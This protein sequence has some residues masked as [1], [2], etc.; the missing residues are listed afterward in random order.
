[1]QQ[2]YIH[3]SCSKGKITVPE[4]RYGSRN[5]RKVLHVDT[6]AILSPTSIKL[7]LQTLCRID[8]SSFLQP[9]LPSSTSIW[10]AS[11]MLFSCSTPACVHG[12]YVCVYVCASPNKVQTLLKMWYPGV[13]GMHY[14]ADWLT[15]LWC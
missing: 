9:P 5:A 6:H 3:T 8:S 2:L 11:S 14:C 13:N 1:M 12:V 15:G 4:D 7:H 10:S